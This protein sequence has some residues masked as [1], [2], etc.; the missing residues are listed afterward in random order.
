MFSG[1][2]DTT[3]QQ[4]NKY[5]AQGEMAKHE[6]DVIYSSWVMIRDICLHKVT[7]FH[8]S[9]HPDISPKQF[10]QSIRKY[11][12]GHTNDGTDP[13]AQVSSTCS[14][15]LYSSLHWGRR[16]AELFFSTHTH[17]H[18]TVSVPETVNDTSDG[19][20][21]LPISLHCIGLYT[22]YMYQLWYKTTY[23]STKYTSSSTNYG[24]CNNYQLQY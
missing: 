9:C 3:L 20:K 19:G 24:W 14:P 17:T 6:T 7:P 15:S 16:R 12:K 23:S 1:R 4:C 18:Y 13:N 21:E 8:H 5:M 2:E 22:S 11:L 10:I